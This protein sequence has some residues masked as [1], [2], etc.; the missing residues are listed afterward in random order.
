ML[1]IA[2]ISETALEQIFEEY[3]T[4]MRDY[5]GGYY[6]TDKVALAALTHHLIPCTL[7]DFNCYSLTMRWLSGR[8]IYPNV[9]QRRVLLP[10]F[11]ISFSLP[12]LN[13][14][15]CNQN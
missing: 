6:T 14:Y 11:S 1:A 4:E 5:L 15:F 13:R 7:A 8:R 2:D 10:S 3:L 12:L 9:D